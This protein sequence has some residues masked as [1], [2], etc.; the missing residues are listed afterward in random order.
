MYLKKKKF[1][2]LEIYS[3]EQPVVELEK[4]EVKLLYMIN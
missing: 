2:S 4:I 1:I 3:L